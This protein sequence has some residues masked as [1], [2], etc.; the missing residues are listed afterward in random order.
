MPIVLF[1]RALMPIVASL[2]LLGV[3]A[4]FTQATTVLTGHYDNQPDDGYDA[5]GPGAF[6][7]PADTGGTPSATFDNNGSAGIYASNGA[8]ITVNGGEFD[9]DVDGGIYSLYSDVVVNG[10]SFSSSI[11]NGSALYVYDHTLSITGGTFNADADIYVYA[12]AVTI[13][14]GTFSHNPGTL[15]T[16]FYV[17]SGNKS[18]D[19]YGQFDGLTVGQSEQ[20]SVGGLPATFTGTL[21]NETSPQTFTYRG[22]GGVITLHDV[23]SVPEPASITALG[24]L[25][26]MGL[27]RRRR[28]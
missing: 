17:Y 16:D 8:M 20:L 14:G 11:V 12:A 7:V 22:T 28:S 23:T 5:E 25:L 19:V 24:G 9:N 3:A 18:F 1:P 15:T 13:T 10:G 6:L 21:V 26:F 2:L 4:P 27:M